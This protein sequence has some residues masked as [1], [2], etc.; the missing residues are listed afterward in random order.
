MRALLQRVRHAKVEIGGELAGE[1]EAGLL[2]FLGVA[3]GD[4]RETADRLLEKILGYRVFAD[5]D[6]RMNL[7]LRD[8]GGG[9]LV[10]SQF[11]LVAD[12][13]KGTR[14]GFSTAGKPA[15]SE[16]LYDYLVARARQQHA[17]VATGEFGADMQVTLTNDG[18]V[19]FLLEA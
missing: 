14:P 18:P 19:T 10:V 4:Q 2:V 16:A 9:L 15:D 1:I 6:G 3:R 8:T 12:T 5:L 17:R 7:S 13:R 11:T